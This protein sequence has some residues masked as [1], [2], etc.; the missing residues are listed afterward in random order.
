MSR[1]EQ[2]E[3]IRDRM[4]NLTKD[5]QSSV[6]WFFFGALQDDMTEA[7]LTRLQFAVTHAEE[8]K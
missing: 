2:I 4:H 8:P 3:A 6:L 7:V 5:Q 1:D